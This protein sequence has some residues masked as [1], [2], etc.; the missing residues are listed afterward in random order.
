MR[1][2]PLY[3]AP[4]GSGGGEGS[5]LT[6]RCCFNPRCSTLATC[7]HTTSCPA[8]LNSYLPSEAN[9]TLPA[10]SATAWHP[11]TC[12]R[13]QCVYGS[14]SARTEDHDCRESVCFVHQYISVPETGVPHSTCA[15]QR[16]NDVLLTNCT[17]TV[18]SRQE[19]VA[20]KIIT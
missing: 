5:F 4:T 20:C 9:P 17:E 18:S 11:Q 14:L 13:N 19:M 8:S 15:R 2:F 6:L 16:H 10:P 12:H 7:F 1:L 3:L